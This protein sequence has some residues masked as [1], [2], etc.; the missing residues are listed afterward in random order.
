MFPG[1]HALLVRI[2]YRV[3]YFNLIP[4]GYSCRT[5]VLFDNRIGQAAEFALWSPCT[6]SKKF[7]IQ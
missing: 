3:F 5:R 7:H 4:I 2:V 6:R 1:F